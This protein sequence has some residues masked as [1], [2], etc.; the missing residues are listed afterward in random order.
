MANKSEFERITIVLKPNAVKEYYNLLPNLASWLQRR[1]KTIQFLAQDE[2]RVQKIFQ[3]KS[4]KL[5]SYIDATKCFRK[6]DL[7]ITLGGDGT[8][9][10]T[11]RLAGRSKTPIFGVNLGHLGFIT[12]FSKNEFYEE[13]DKIFR[14]DLTVIPVPLITAEVVGKD[15]ATIKEIFLND[16]VVSKYEM[17]RMLG[18][19]LTIND[20]HVY[21][22]SGDGIIISSAL[23]STAYSLAA[24][25]PIMHPQVRALIVTPICPHSLSYRP[26]VVP[27]TY[28][29]QI[30]VNSAHDQV[31]LTLDGQR[32]V[33]I[34]QTDKLF[35]KKD[36]KNVVYLVKN[37]Q[38]YY[39]HTLKEKFDHGKRDHRF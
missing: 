18:L 26:M 23:G 31:T 1:K 3:N 21:N 24:G 6:S 39:F 29:I 25:G 33:Q 36:P 12:E 7:I 8:L 13:L 28:D 11:A 10:G 30:Q 35:I 9:I 27:E 4:K 37:P 17:S 19:A 5:F 2:A 16:A 22:F 15:K 34:S 20:E 14:G 32:A 38:R